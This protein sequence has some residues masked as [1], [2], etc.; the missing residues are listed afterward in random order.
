MFPPDIAFD[1]ADEVKQT[2]SLP[3]VESKALLF[4]SLIDND[5]HFHF[6]F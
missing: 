5:F 1:S 3:G 6:S 2:V 4:F